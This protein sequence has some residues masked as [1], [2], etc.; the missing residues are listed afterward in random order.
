MLSLRDKERVWC[1]RAALSACASCCKAPRALGEGIFR[2][3]RFS[4]RE[5]QR[6]IFGIFLNSFFT[7]C[8]V[9]RSLTELGAHWLPRKPQGSPLSLQLQHWDCRCTPVSMSSLDTQQALY[10][11]SLSSAVF[12]LF[13]RSKTNIL[14]RSFHLKS[15]VVNEKQTLKVNLVGAKAPVTTWDVY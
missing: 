11:P 2:I 5:A 3:P 6:S 4:E 1:W 12:W 15:L 8:L 7:L 9:T 14:V 13:K 10:Q